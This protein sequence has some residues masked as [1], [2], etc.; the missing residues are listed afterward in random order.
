[1]DSNPAPYSYKVTVLTIA[2]MKGFMRSR[3]RLSTDLAH[4]CSFIGGLEGQSGLFIFQS[5]LGHN[6]IES[7][8]SVDSRRSPQTYWFR[9]LVIFF[10]HGHWRGAIISLGNFCSELAPLVSVH[11][12]HEHNS[13]TKTYS[14]FCFLFVTCDSV[15]IAM[16]T[17]TKSQHLLILSKQCRH[18]SELDQY[19]HAGSWK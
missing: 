19:W 14:S 15:A 4:K 8:V 11:I 9:L 18:K 6:E 2:L 7:Y 17:S 12:Q 13:H 3:H 1:M 16:N 5:V 10:F